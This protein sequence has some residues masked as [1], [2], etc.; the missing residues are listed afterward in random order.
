MGCVVGGLIPDTTFRSITR[1]CSKSFATVTINEVFMGTFL[2]TEVVNADW[3]AARM[4]SEPLLYKL[5]IYS[6]AYQ[7]EQQVRGLVYACGCAWRGGL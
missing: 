3:L 2:Q 6:T 5:N 1:A 7:G 4:M